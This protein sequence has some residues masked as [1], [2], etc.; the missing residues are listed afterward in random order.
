MQM[1]DP[2][3]R[4]AAAAVAGMS[5]TYGYSP[6]PGDI[7]RCE[8]PFVGGITTGVVRANNGTYCLVS[9]GDEVLAYYPHELKWTGERVPE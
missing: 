5:D 8:P 2:H 9:I 7:V 4:E 3:A 6:T 1:T